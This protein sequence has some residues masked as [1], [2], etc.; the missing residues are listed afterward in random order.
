M[1]DKSLNALLYAIKE[2]PSVGRTHI[3]KIPFLVDLISYN[4]LGTTFLDDTYLRMPYGPVSSYALSKTDEFFIK[5]DEDLDCTSRALS[6]GN[7][8][9]SYIPRKEP[10]L[11]NFDPYEFYIFTK[12]LKKVSH[13]YA[14][15]ISDYTHELKLW[16]NNKDLETI[17]LEQ[18]YLSPDEAETLVLYGFS[19]II[20]EQQFTREINLF[21]REVSKMAKPDLKDINLKLDQFLDKFPMEYENLYYDIY[22]AWDDVFRLLIKNYPNL[23]ADLGKQFCEN[24]CITTNESGHDEYKDFVKIAH[25]DYHVKIEQTYDLILN[26]EDAS[27]LHDKILDN[28]YIQLMKSSYNSLVNGCDSN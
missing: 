28:A 1:S 15:D 16:L 6:N 8:K 10:D 13:M 2:Y 12:V 20:Q 5:F 17:P 18:F 27:I 3:V 19:N 21:S 22:L 4:Q 25:S 7:K 23:A 26:E 14:T 11:N 9:Y 24:Y